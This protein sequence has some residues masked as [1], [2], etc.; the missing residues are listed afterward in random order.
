M[1]M[2]E[3]RR[4]VRLIIPGLVF[5]VEVI[6]LLWLLA[7]EWTGRK[8]TDTATNSSLVEII[9]GTLVASGGAGFIFSMVH[10]RLHFLE[11]GT[12]SHLR[13]VKSL[14][15]RGLLELINARTGE[16]LKADVS[17]DAPRDA[18]IIVASIWE[19]R[20][21]WCKIIQAA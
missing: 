4:F 9:V 6:L 12:R 5:G 18:W 16:T 3:A 11:S 2:S 13:L 1:L 19:E 7:P 10:H 15:D 20:K 8:L 14:R 17:L 21:A